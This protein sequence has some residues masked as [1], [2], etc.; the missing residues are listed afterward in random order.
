[1]K[2]MESFISFEPSSFYMAKDSELVREVEDFLKEKKIEIVEMEYH[3]DFEHYMKPTFSVLTNNYK[4]LGKLAEETKS[5]FVTTYDE[6]SYWKAISVK[7][8]KYEIHIY[9][10][11]KPFHKC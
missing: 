9:H 7:N 6:R 8:D 2:T 1:M 5:K 11:G 3:R 4:S 10:R